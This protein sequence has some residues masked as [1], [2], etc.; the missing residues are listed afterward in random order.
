M[1]K[2]VKSDLAKRQIFDDMA[3]K[4]DLPA[5]IKEIKD[6]TKNGPYAKTY[7]ILASILAAVAERAIELNDPALNILMLQLALYE[8][9]HINF[10]EK[11][12]KLREKVKIK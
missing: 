8:D 6:C 10:L 7:E 2:L 3:W 5:F 12:Q 9:T 11:V 4:V 1:S